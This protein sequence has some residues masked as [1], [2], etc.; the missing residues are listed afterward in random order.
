MTWEQHVYKLDGVDA[1]RFKLSAMTD[2]ELLACSQAMSIG[3]KL[4]EMQSARDHFLARDGEDDPTDVELEALGQAWSEHCCYKSSK[5]VLKANVYGI[6]EDKIVAR[7]D[8]GVVEF[9][10]NHYYVVGLESHN[11][12]SAIEPYGGAATG[13][14]GIIRDIVCMGA[15]PVAL[16]DP[17]FFG[18]L[19]TKHS[20]LPPGVKHPRFIMDGVVSGIRDYGNRVGIPTVAGGVTFH[21]GYTGNPLVNVGCIG[22]VEKDRMIHSKA[23]G[24]GDVFVYVGNATGRDGIHGV[25]FASEELTE[26]SE[27][28]SRSAVQVGDAI[29]KEPLIHVTLE[30]LEEDLATGCKDFGGGGLSCVAGELAYDAGYGCVINLETIP[31]KVP[32]MSP[33]E[34]W[35]SESQ[36]RMMFTAKPENVERILQIAKKWDVPAVVCGEVTETTVNHVKF[37]GKTVMKLDLEFSTG[38]PTYNRPAADVKVD[39]DNFVDYTAPDAQET[40]RKLFAHPSIMSKEWVIRQYDHEVRANTVLKPLQGVIGLEGPG[41]AAVLKPVATSDKGLALVSDINPR[42]MERDPY[43]GSAGAIDEVVRNLTAVGARISSLCD[44]LNFGN[45]EKPERMWELYESTRG[46]GDMARKLG[47][48]FSSG[49]VSL[50][51]ETPQGPIPP[52]PT[53]MGVGILSHFKHA[54]SLDLKSPGNKLYLVGHTFREL[55]GSAYADVIGIDGERVPQTDVECLMDNAETIVTAIENGLIRAAHD[56]SEGGIAV[57]LAEMCFAG[58]LGANVT[59]ADVGTRAG[60]NLD[61]DQK[62]FSESNSRWIVE[63]PAD[64]ADDFEAMFP[65]LPKKNYL[66][67]LGEVTEGNLVID[68]AI[69]MDPQE[70]RTIWSETL[71]K[72]MGATA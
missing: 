48:P 43:W 10:D 64:K 36:E 23:G 69:N 54:T 49:N 7:E 17:I 42:Y 45:P 44:N 26:E 47:V 8:G 32:G 38:G 31:L 5:P 24:P 11:H 20:D 41:D 60:A 33:W 29:L 15:Q 63:V 16:V 22:M 13:V 61:Y 4:D 3:L 57:A 50:Y 6:H 51:N 19:D 25:A 72:L 30:V 67:N 62:L 52:T 35:V 39:R 70:L 1:R 2:A 46:L 9:D 34:I 58:G 37:D 53:I 21:P 56:C 55:G 40:L 65:E 66:Y 27:D 71:P 14:G 18:P 12:P 28:A 68:D 59:L